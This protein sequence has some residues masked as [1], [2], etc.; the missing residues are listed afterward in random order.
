MLG[1]SFLQLNRIR[2]IK[3]KSVFLVNFI[4]SMCLCKDIEEY[5]IDKRL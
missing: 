2:A 1:F 3:N 5:F 4:S